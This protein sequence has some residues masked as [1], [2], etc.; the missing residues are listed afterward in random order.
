M[1]NSFD[2]PQCDDN[3]DFDNR[4]VSRLLQDSHSCHRCDSTVSGSGQPFC[5]VIAEQ[6]RKA[7]NS[8]VEN[9][10]RNRGRA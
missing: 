7:M 3:I 2:L 8:I 6:A 4:D 5:P 1:N 9:V 10:L